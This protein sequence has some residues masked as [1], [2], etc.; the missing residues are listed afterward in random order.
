MV[1]QEAPLD[2]FVVSKLGVPCHEEFAMG[3]IASRGA[4][5][6]DDDVIRG[7][8]IEAETVHDLHEL[9]KEVIAAP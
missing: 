4:V 1:D 5:V 2:V 8:G 6:V 9:G 7:L 3:A